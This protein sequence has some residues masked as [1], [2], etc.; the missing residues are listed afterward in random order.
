MFSEA[1]RKAAGCDFSL[2]ALAAISYLKK[3]HGWF[4]RV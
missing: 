1:P 2:A 4:G 3:C